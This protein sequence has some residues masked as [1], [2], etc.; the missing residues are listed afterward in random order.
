MT[1]ETTFV[2][3]LSSPRKPLPNKTPKPESAEGRGYDGDSAG[4]AA[5]KSRLS[6]AK[7]S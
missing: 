1:N 7:P 5:R 3:G 6:E 2:M 4:K